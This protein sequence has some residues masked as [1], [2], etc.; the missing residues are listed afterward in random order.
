MGKFETI[1][2]CVIACHVWN[3]V[4]VGGEWSLSSPVEDDACLLI[5]LPFLPLV[6]WVGIL[7]V[8]TFLVTVQSDNLT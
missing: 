2:P 7:E 3:V 4:G 6:V 8:K 5:E 1:V